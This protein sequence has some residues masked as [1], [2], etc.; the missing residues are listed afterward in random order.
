MIKIFTIVNKKL[1]IA[2]IPNSKLVSNNGS[3]CTNNAYP[4]NIPV[5]TAGGNKDAEIATPTKLLVLF[6]NTDNATPIPLGNA[7][8]ILSKILLFYFDP[9]SIH[10][11]RNRDS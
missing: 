8:K 4:S 10:V 6:P 1:H 3:K 7:I 2:I 5:F 11:L 9:E